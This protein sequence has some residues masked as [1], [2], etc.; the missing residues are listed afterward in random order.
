MPGPG[1]IPGLGI[2]TTN[3]MNVTSARVQIN[4]CTSVVIIADETHI[5]FS[6]RRA[7]LDVH[8][9]DA[10]LPVARP[11]CT[12]LTISRDEL[13]ADICASPGGQEH[14]RLPI[15]RPLF[16]TIYGEQHGELKCGLGPM[17]DLTRLIL[18]FLY[19]S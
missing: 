14:A 10:P 9:P 16:A 5:M 18:M 19:S 6:V 8:N 2:N 12:T 1:P 13:D 4:S 15:L 11:S 3:T 7:S 17:R